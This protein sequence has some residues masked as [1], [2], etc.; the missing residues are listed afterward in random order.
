[1]KDMDIKN[2][3]I[4]NKEYIP[5]SYTQ[6]SCSKACATKH[7]NN[8]RKE[9]YKK[10]QEA[11]RKAKEDK[12]IEKYGDKG[13]ED[14]K[15]ITEQELAI[16]VDKEIKLELELKKEKQRKIDEGKKMSKE[17]PILEKLRDFNRHTNSSNIQVLEVFLIGMVKELEKMNAKAE[18]EIYADHRNYGLNMEIDSLEGSLN[19]SKYIIK[20]S[21]KEIIKLKEEISFLKKMNKNLSLDNKDLQKLR[22]ENE[23]FRKKYSI[24]KGGKPIY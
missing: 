1:M 3:I 6:K 20:K 12:V 15:G 18:A 14:L 23:F 10:Q 4:C 9:K 24:G 16:L 17:H 19:V 13:L 22:K 21:K 7:R 2:C 11:K 8:T 5:K